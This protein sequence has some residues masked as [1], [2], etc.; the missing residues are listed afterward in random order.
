MDFLS[1]DAF[2]TASIMPDVSHVGGKTARIPMRVARKGL[3]GAGLSDAVFSS[4][5]F[6]GA[7]LSL[8]TLFSNFSDEEACSE[9]ALVP[10]K[11]EDDNTFSLG[12]TKWAE[13][14]KMLRTD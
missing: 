3:G 9:E 1:C 13:T 4:T 8:E 10:K 12:A 11:S 7:R 6:S 14:V 5:V 2:L